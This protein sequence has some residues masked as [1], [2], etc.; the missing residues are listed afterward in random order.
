M[1]T[2]K[3]IFLSLFLFVLFTNS[4]FAQENRI[5]LPQINKERLSLQK[6]SMYVLG[7]WSV[8]N[9]AYSG[10][11][12][13]TGVSNGEDK[14][15]H[16]FNIYWNTVNFALAGSSLLFGKKN[17]DLN[18]SQT[19]KAYHST[20][21]LFLLNTG[22]DV[23]YMA[24]G[25]YLRERAKTETT[26]K[27]TNRFLGYGKSLILQGGFLFAFDL[28]AYALNKRQSNTL[29]EIPVSLSLAPNQ[30]RFTYTF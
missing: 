2:K 9:F 16:Q 5:D 8:A 27:N 20:E 11:T 3:I 12:L 14:Y 23:G 10:A 7:G 4:S 25:L 24:A 6:N 30:M 22:I 1:F 13:A 18:Y 28:T 15:F 26:I 19:L 29:Y 21:S 17:T